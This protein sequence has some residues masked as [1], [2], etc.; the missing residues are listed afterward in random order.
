MARVTRREWIALAAAAFAL[1]LGVRAMRWGID[2]GDPRRALVRRIRAE[3]D[4]ARDIVIVTDEAPE[5]VAAVAPVPAVWGAQSMH[6]V[7]AFRRLY[8]VANAQG[9]IGPY[10]ARLGRPTATLGPNVVSWT[11]DGLRTVRFDLT[12]ELLDHTTARREGGRFDGPC[13]RVGN[14]L[15]CNSTDDWNHPHVAEHTMAGVAVRCVHAHPQDQSA[16]I[17]ET[18][19]IPSAQW[20]VGMVGMNDHAIN[21][22]GASVENHVTFTPTDGGPVIVTDIIA[23]N[24]AGATPYRLALGGHPGT[25]RFSITTANA[26]AR[27][28]CFTAVATE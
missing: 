4:P 15:R 20:L 25:L 6:D 9:P 7:G 1:M 28:Y 21:A 2:K 24:R 18:H 19:A 16:L 13:P 17:F 5:L 27:Q 22:T 10:E 14:V 3:A 23:P 8:V 26:G 11:L 12:A